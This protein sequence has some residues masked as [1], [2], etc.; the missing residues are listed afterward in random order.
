MEEWLHGCLFYGEKESCKMSV[1]SFDLDNTICKT[2]GT[3]YRSS[4]PIQEMVDAI[5]K[6]YPNNYI[7]ILTARGSRSGKNWRELTESQLKDWGIKYH[8]L[9]FQKPFAHYYIGNE[10]MSIEEFKRWMSQS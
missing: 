5:N 1:F 8:E 4:E 6:L 10:A 9:S 7:R 3:D 2:K